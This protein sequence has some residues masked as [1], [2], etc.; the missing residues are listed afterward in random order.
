[1]SRLLRLDSF[2]PANGTLYA[3]HESATL[4]VG[5]NYAPQGVTVSVIANPD[6]GF[7][8][9]KWSATAKTNPPP[10]RANAASLKPAN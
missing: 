4:G 3:K 9:L 10:N 2:L 6:D 7:Y 1:M 5:V 8:L